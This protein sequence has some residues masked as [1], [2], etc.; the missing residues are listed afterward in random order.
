MPDLAQ[1]I[2]I[3]GRTI[4]NFAEAARVVCDCALET[5]IEAAAL[6]EKL[7]A[8]ADPVSLEQQFRDWAEQEGLLAVAENPPIELIPGISRPSAAAD[9]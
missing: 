2:T 5:D 3:K 7:K 6:C 1:P 4:T 8:G 9:S